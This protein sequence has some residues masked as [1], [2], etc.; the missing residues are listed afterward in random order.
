[1]Y[2]WWTY[3]WTNICMKFLIPHTKFDVS[4]NM[5]ISTDLGME[6][7]RIVKNIKMTY[8]FPS[9]PDVVSNTNYWF[10]RIFFTFDFWVHV[11]PSSIIKSLMKASIE[12]QLAIAPNKVD[13]QYN[14][15]TI[16]IHCCCWSTIALQPLWMKSAD[17]QLLVRQVTSGCHR[18]LQATLHHTIKVQ[19]HEWQTT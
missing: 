9:L 16:L 2:L 3:R 5:N 14:P 15:K 11:L 12:G 13:C 1:M 4:A 18:T 19:S 8:P 17:N 7:G 10:K 6:Y